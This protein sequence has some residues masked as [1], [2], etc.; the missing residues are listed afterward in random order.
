MLS[1]ATERYNKRRRRCELS[2]AA[3]LCAQLC[4][5]TPTKAAEAVTSA[6]SERLLA[7]RRRRRRRQRPSV[8]LERSVVVLGPVCHWANS[9]GGRTII[10]R[11]NFRL[12]ARR[13][14]ALQGESWRRYDLRCIGR[15]LELRR[16][17][18]VA[19]LSCHAQHCADTL[20]YCMWFGCGGGQM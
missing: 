15:P 14:T 19:V 2:R 4:A 5:H 12:R 7:G 3:A 1:C 20:N 6:Q 8:C 10:A 16:A 18:V 9:R 11:D 13:E 17:P